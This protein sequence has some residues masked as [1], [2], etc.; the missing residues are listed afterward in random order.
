MDYFRARRFLDTLP[1]WEKGPPPPGPVEHYLPRM[2]ALLAR[3]GAPQGG[4]RSVIVG[5]T[6]GKGTTASLLAALLHRLPREPL[7]V[8]LYTSP[9]LH[10][11]RERI[12]VNGRPFGRDRWAA[13]V[14][15]LFD[16]SRSFEREGL[17]PFT[18]YEALTA[19]A[20]RIFAEEKVDI[21]VWE[22]G[23]GGR[24]DATN[25]WDS[26]LALLTPV[27]LDH[28]DVLGD[29]ILEIAAD[30]L[31]IARPGHALLTTRT[32]APEVL[33][34]ARRTCERRDIELVA[35]P[36]LADAGHAGL[37]PGTYPVNAG[38]ALAAAERLLP[39]EYD[40]GRAAGLAAD[41]AWPGRFEKAA[42]RPF[43]LLDGAHNPAAARALAADLKRLAPRW[44]LVLGA[45]AGHDSEGLLQALA[46]LAST[47]VLTRA[48]H[49]KA[50]DPA[51]LAPLVPDG[52]R[53]LVR[54]TV[55]AALETARSAAG[56]D[57]HLC[58]TGSL[59]AVAAA[60]ECLGL[61]ED[62]E[63]ISEDVALE[64]L[65]CLELACRRL[66]LPCP[67]PSANGT[68]RRVDTARGPLYFWRNK[69]PFND[70]VGARLAEDK[71]FQHELFSQAGLPL[72]QTMQVF[73]PLADERFNRYKTH[74][75]FA[76][77]VDDIEN[78]LAYPLVVKKYRSSVSQGVFVEEG[79]ETLL[80]RLRVLCENSAFSDNILL[81]QSWVDGP[82]YRAVASGG[83]LLLAY[84]KQGD[85]DRREHLNPLHHPGGRAEKITDPALL[86]RLRGLT[87]RVAD[88]VPLGFYAID[89]LDGPDGLCILEINPNPFC[90]FYNRSNGRADFVAIYEK[91]LRRHLDITST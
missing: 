17:G 59:Y 23:L 85:A 83:E 3:M 15:R 51:D 53:V 21:A 52:P 67:S 65:A 69:H 28:T 63:G 58:V 81:V 2:R 39:G 41:H 5:G 31:D 19:L 27:S 20:A 50:L 91:L 35:V 1:D 26:E 79:R 70:Y 13:A 84:H 29:D 56:D 87:R 80:R 88:V 7:R 82:E 6:N 4:F 36:P 40:G 10:T 72:P 16:A 43:T 86:D 68:L 38:L 33:D 64:S 61:A 47:L 12:Q 14:E 57:G 54:P 48:D 18:R 22:V 25:A 73:N 8:G 90:Y 62:G 49:A 66:D 74:A 78:R 9:H 34:L 76:E 11:Q 24:Y 55:H 71:A 75:S 45:S 89:L 30:K 46:P 44:T 37:K 42:D 60:R 32:Q 77:M